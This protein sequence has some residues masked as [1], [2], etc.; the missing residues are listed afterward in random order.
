MLRQVLSISPFGRCRDSFSIWELT[1]LLAQLQP[2]LVVVNQNVGRVPAHSAKAAEDCAHSKTLRIHATIS[3][4][5]KRLG[6]RAVLCR[7]GLGW[8][9]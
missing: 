7:F 2:G 4:R 6:V 5:R 8:L 9:G 1:A 3:A